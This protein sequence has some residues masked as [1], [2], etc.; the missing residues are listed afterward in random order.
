MMGTGWGGGIY[1]GTH[2]LYVGT[3]LGIADLICELCMQGPRWGLKR[4]VEIPVVY[5]YVGQ[6]IG[7]LCWK[8][9]ESMILFWNSCL[10]SWDWPGDCRF[11]S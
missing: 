4:Y 8:W 2:V 1:F 3:S 9:F 7:H 5:V 6:E 11:Y 10:V